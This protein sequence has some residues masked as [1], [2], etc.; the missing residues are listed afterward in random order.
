MKIKKYYRMAKRSL[1]ERKK[2]TRST[3]RG[4]AVGFIILLPII[5][6][7]WGINVS[8]NKQL[9]EKPYLLHYNVSN[10]TDYRIEMDNYQNAFVSGSKNIDFFDND[11]LI[12][13]K[14]VYTIDK[15]IGKNDN[16]TKYKIEENGF[17]P[18]NQLD[19]DH[20]SIIDI[21]KSDSYFPNNLTNYFPNGI[22]LEGYSQG[23]TNNGKK[24]VIISQKMLNSLGIQPDDI[25]KKSLTISSDSYRDH[26]NS[27]EPISGF[28]CK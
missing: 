8:F 27:Q 3:V 4:L 19:I 17:H 13:N 25:Y 5:V 12:T 9:N 1:K 14:I 18:I 20:Y 22:F 10:M 11:K 28:I 24:Q 16:S 6:C 21:D 23:F 26:I 7:L 2:N 15:L